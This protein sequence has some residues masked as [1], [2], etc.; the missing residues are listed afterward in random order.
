MKLKSLAFVSFTLA[1]A[2]LSADFSFQ[3]TTKITGGS[4]TK[5]MRFVPGGGKTLEP[6]TSYVYLKGDRLAHVFPDSMSII[7]LAAGTMTEVNL[8]KKTYSS[9]TF[10]EMREAM[11]KMASQM[12]E[13]MAKN[14]NAAE[15]APQMDMTFSI[16]RTGQQRSI[17]GLDT[18]EYVMLI[19]MGA[20]A[21]ANSA[22]VGLSELETNM[23]M[24]T[25]IPG[26][27]EVQAFYLRM[28]QKMGYSPNMNPLLMQQRGSAEGMKKMVEEM[29]KLDGTPVMTITRMKG[30]SAMA[31]LMGPRPSSGE[32]KER[33]SGNPFG[34]GLAGMAAGGILGRRKNKEK[35]KAE[36][37][38]APA[39][40]Q[41]DSVM[42]EMQSE[43]SN[44]SSAAIAAGKMDVP[45]GFEP[46][47]HPMKKALKRK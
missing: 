3:E 39:A 13:A 27:D 19:G 43:S 28:S 44:F 1:L 47:E 30:T 23:W 15:P 11:E 21:D 32:N 35:E 7:D 40:P 25:K 20:K 16:K 33:A 17:S 14:K 29:S 36:E 5:M 18:R 9:I 37:A 45:A 38:A 31:G 34:G 26:Y 41:D 12:Q 4:L 22:P 6:K 46:V 24:T 42:M 10:A 8:E 2:P